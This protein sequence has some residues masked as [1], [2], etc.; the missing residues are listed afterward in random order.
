MSTTT[1]AVSLLS[2]NDVE[3]DVYTYQAKDKLYYK[4]YQDLVSANIQYNQ[5]HLNKLGLGGGNNTNKRKSNNTS[6][7]SNKKSKKIPKTT[8]T[9]PRRASQRLRNV[10]VKDMNV[11]DTLDELENTSIKKKKTWTKIRGS[12]T[13]TTKSFQTL[14]EE[15]LMK[16]KEYFDKQDGD[17]EVWMD[18]MH[19]WLLKVPHGWKDNQKTVS[20]PNA[21]SVMRQ[22]RKLVIDGSKGVGIMYHHWDDNIEFCWWKTAPGYDNDDDEEN[23]TPTK[24]KSN[25]DNNSRPKQ[26]IFTCDL[27]HIYNLAQ[28]M[29][30]THGR[31]LGNGW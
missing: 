6:T 1:I 31:D 2:S 3:T 21:R 9:E 23:T 17:D 12:N 24:S 13:T 14:N 28:E 10:P 7:A 15:E 18:D 19:H 4:S 5:Q 11:L 30:D 29:E 26:H 16:L 27:Q 25:D 8:T 22:V 20:E